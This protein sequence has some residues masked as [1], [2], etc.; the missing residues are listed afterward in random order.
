MGC[1]QTFVST[2]T[3]RSP[4][5]S[6]DQTLSTSSA[7]RRSLQTDRRLGPIFTCT[8]SE[9]VVPMGLGTGLGMDACQRR[10]RRAVAVPCCQ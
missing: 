1:C 6:L 4:H 3:N 7:K 9:S 10:A 5:R 8:M 2:R